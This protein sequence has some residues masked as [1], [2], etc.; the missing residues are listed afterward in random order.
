MQSI[1]INKLSLSVAEFVA[2]ILKSITP[3]L[4]LMAAVLFWKKNYI[5]HYRHSLKKIN[6][7]VRAICDGPLQHYFQDILFFNEK[8][9]EQIIG[10]CS[11]CGNC[12]LNR[13]CFF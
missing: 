4:P 11:Q 2:F 9:E 7:H 6:I 1:L 13:Q 5:A 10:H 3:L 8:V 12:C